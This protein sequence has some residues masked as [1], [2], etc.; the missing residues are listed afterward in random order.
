MIEPGL[1][2]GTIRHR[3][4]APRAHAF[5]Y[6]LFMPLLDIDRLPEAMAV[7]PLTGYNRRRL[8]AF[9]DRDHFGD[10]ALPLRVRVEQSARDH[11]VA[12]P[13][14]PIY[15]LT[16][17]RYAGYVFNPISL[18]YCTDGQGRVP[19]VLAEVNN[20]YGGRQL[21]WLNGRGD[22]GP[23]RDRVAKAMYVSPFMDYD[24]DYAFALTAPGASLVA[25]MDVCRP[26][27][28]RRDRMFDATLF[29]Q[30]RPWT[31][32]ELHRALVRFPLMT[33]KV[34]AAIHWEALR[35]W[36]KGLAVKPFPEDQGHE[37]RR[38]AT[39]R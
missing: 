11:G 24:V 17:L 4:F 16:H 30:R 25:H 22:N 5:E 1:Y 8:A 7:S 28:T 38:H 20:T 3:R 14:G 26:G 18:Y 23:L 19:A 33:A 12:L 39:V 32:R 35:L 15:L 36:M 37:E 13:A 9:D 2:V 27:E 10:P 34:T 29:L 31:A 21:Y 6:S